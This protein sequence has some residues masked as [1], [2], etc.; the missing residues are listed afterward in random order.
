MKLKNPPQVSLIQKDRMSVKIFNE[1]LS[2]EW[3]WLTRY[4]D[5]PESIH[6]ETVPRNQEIL[7][8]RQ[9]QPAL[10]RPSEIASLAEDMLRNSPIKNIRSL[11]DIARNLDNNSLDITAQITQDSSKE[12]REFLIGSIF[13]I[14]V[15]F[16]YW[17]VWRFF[18]SQ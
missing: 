14:G 17:L 1:N 5:I 13:T 11:M 7:E 15:I 18:L 6:A 9:K 12:H 3:G 2:I 4:H 8:I 16:F 10:Y